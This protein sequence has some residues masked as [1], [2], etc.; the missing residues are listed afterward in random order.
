MTGD[1]IAEAL[2]SIG[3][4]HTRAQ[5]ELLQLSLR[6]QNEG[7]TEHTQ[8]A[9]LTQYVMPE[10]AQEDLLPVV[11]PTP[12]V[13]GARPTREQALST[14]KEVLRHELHNNHQSHLVHLVDQVS[15][16]DIDAM[17]QV[18]AMPSPAFPTPV[19]DL[20]NMEFFRGFFNAQTIEGGRGQIGRGSF[21]L[22]QYEEDVRVAKQADLTGWP[23]GFYTDHTNQA[24]QFLLNQVPPGR[25]ILVE[26]LP[27]GDI[28]VSTL[29]YN[30]GEH[31][32]F[33]PMAPARLDKGAKQFL[34]VC[35]RQA[36]RM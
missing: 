13:N 4:H 15:Q 1:E 35:F 16:S 29:N 10:P 11:P 25:A 5:R 17:H 24:T 27:R 31:A 18:A 30:E 22:T 12:A 3:Q 9:P 7:R 21:G 36:F 2:A 19:R 28:R 32:S 23:S 8:C 6:L 14:A 26:G 33:T 20:T 34:T